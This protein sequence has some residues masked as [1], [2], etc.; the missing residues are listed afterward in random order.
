MPRLVR[1]RLSEMIEQCLAH[2]Q[3][4]D[5]RY[6]SDKLL[7]ELQKGKV[8]VVGTNGHCLLICYLEL[9]TEYE[10]SAIIPHDVAKVAAK[11]KGPLTIAQDDD[12]P[13]NK[14]L[15][16]EGKKKRQ[17]A[18]EAYIGPKPFP[19]Y[20]KVVERE[21]VPNTKVGINGQQLMDALKLC[22]TMAGDGNAIRLDAQD[23]AVSLLS[24]SP[25]LGE[26]RYEVENPVVKGAKVSIG[27]NI[28]YLQNYAKFHTEDRIWFDIL[29][30]GVATHIYVD[31]LDD[32]FVLMPVRL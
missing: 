25:D 20:H 18:L 14:W 24:S 15:V 16:L 12:P 19:D 6:Y 29:D 17:L 4:G 32:R 30:P 26:C 5:E 31:G 28:T 27:Y 13:H 1:S 8:T 2:T 10:V 7:F 23:G 22:K 11:H 3:R 21:L 9:P